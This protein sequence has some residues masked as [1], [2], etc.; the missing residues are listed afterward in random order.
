MTTSAITESA[1]LDWVTSPGATATLHVPAMDGL[2]T[3]VEWLTAAGPALRTALHEH[4]AIVLRSLPI[5]SVADFG[6]VRDVLLPARTPYR[7]KATPRS[8]YGNGVF[9]ST[10]LP[11]AQR[12][13][14]HN[15]NSYTLTFPGLL[16]FACLVAPPEGGATP[17]ADCRRVLA[18]LPP[19]LVE[20]MRATG[21]L[22]TRSYSEHI[23]TDW[24]TAFA[25][26]TPAD[27]QR[28]CAENLITC[29]WQSDG[30]LRTSQL[31][32]GIITHPVTGEQVWFN[33]LAFWNEW[34]LDDELRETL[35]EEF[36]HDDLPFNTALGDGSS[37]TRDELET[38]AAAYE[39]ATVRQ[40][41]QPG[42]L[43]LVD[44]ILC[45]HGRDAFRGDRKIVVAMGE[46][47]DVLDCSPTV[48]PAAAGR[49][50][51][52]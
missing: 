40:P 49:E 14:M 5:G 46:P 26:D 8:D 2:E 21:W 50:G 25:A 33:H 17:V 1:S 30:H 28:Y 3:A 29:Q 13:R 32:P 18:S 42:D 43:M 4:G 12:I 47:V 39:S 31:R 11:A 6:V 20:R 24:R 23:S 35:I 51:E 41:W 38:L 45:A 22:L 7:E 44:N 48:A 15:E 37:L 9:S 36:G 27:V 34:A 52:R 16:M 19:Q 10:D